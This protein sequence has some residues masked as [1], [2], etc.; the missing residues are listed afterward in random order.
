MLSNDELLEAPK[1]VMGDVFKFLDM[2]YVD[3]KMF[4]VK[5]YSNGSALN[6]ISLESYNKLADFL[7][8]DYKSFC[9]QSGLEF[10]EAAYEGEQ[11]A[12]S[13]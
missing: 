10:K 1:K 11:Q 5:K 8:P 3:N 2:D 6:K 4:G 12:K 7:Y 13:A 9:Q